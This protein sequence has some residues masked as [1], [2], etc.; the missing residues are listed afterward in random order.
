M[1]AVTIVAVTAAI[2]RWSAGEASRIVVVAEDVSPHLSPGRAPASA[3]GICYRVDD[4]GALALEFTTD[5]ATF[6]NWIAEVVAPTAGSNAPGEP[7]QE[8]HNS[9][10][11]GYRGNT[12]T[13][14]SGLIYSSAAEGREVSVT[15]DRAN[16]RV[17]YS[18]D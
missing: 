5:E 1:A 6:R 8:T 2:A 13:V 12:V 11:R 7:L 18:R 17:Y 3:K 4:R 10:A 15:F 14:A 9:V 16:G